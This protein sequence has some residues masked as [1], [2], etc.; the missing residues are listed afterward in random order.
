MYLTAAHLAP[1]SPRERRALLGLVQSFVAAGDRPSAEIVYRRLLESS[2]TEPEILT[3]A[4]KA[5]RAPSGR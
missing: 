1:R 5:L 2:T 4:R 3:E